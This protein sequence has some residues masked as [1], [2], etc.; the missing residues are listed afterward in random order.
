MYSSRITDVA[1]PELYVAS[2][3]P[4]GMDFT[5]TEREPFRACSILF[6]LGR[7]YVQRGREKL[8]RIDHVTTPRGGVIFHTQP[9][10]DMF[11]NGTEIGMNQMALID[12]GESYTSRLSG[13]TQ[14]GTMTLAKE[15]MDAL[16]TPEAGF[17]GNRMS[18]VTVFTPPPAALAHL[19]ALH[20]YTG[21]LAEA[22]PE[23]L[24]N[25]ELAHDLEFNLMAA[26]RETLSTQTSNLNAVASRHHQ[27][28]VNRFRALLG[29]PDDNPMNM[30]EISQ[31]IGV[32][33]RTLRLACQNLFG[34]SPGQYVL[35]RRMRLARRALQR[36]D[37]DVTRV[38]D[39]ATEY[40]FWELVRFAVRYRHFF[41]ESP[42]A[43]LRSCL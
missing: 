12:A 18:G 3:R 9:G 22:T 11:L 39:I 42:S 21:R 16:C 4:I 25:T 34:V 8:T 40:G 31:K 5:V 1:D 36:A 23:L 13:A 32:S 30:A 2:L 33:G 29:A 20:S 41:G 15:D 6:D 26:L 35:L 19:R 37:P 38:T 7:V 17:C 14:W 24:T 10:P 28:I 43:T 27:I